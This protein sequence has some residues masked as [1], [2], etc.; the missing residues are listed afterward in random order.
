M[1]TMRKVLIYLT[2]AMM[3]FALSGCGKVETG[4]AKTAAD[5]RDKLIVTDDETTAQADENTTVDEDIEVTVDE[6]IPAKEDPAVVEIKT[7]KFADFIR[8]RN[9]A[10]TMSIHNIND[11]DDAERQGYII[12]QVNS[13]VENVASLIYN[14]GGEYDEMY[15]FKG[16]AYRAELGENPELIGD[17]PF[18][19]GKNTEEL[20]RRV[21]IKNPDDMEYKGTEK[22][23]DGMIMETFAYDDEEGSG[24]IVYVFDPVKSFLPD[25][26]EIGEQ[27]YVVREY[28]TDVDMACIPQE[29]QDFA[30]GVL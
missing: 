30:N 29:V 10:I 12:T 8:K 28:R 2:A 15:C 24:E 1:D 9:F 13:D 27:K 4:G 22:S 16:K 20:V 19:N 18:F 25:W 7:K 5:S 14:F 11:P 23:T 26:I 3:S 6:T 17:D 21:L